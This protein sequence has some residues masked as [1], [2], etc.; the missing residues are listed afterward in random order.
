VGYSQSEQKSFVGERALNFS[1]IGPSLLVS[2]DLNDNL[3][4]SFDYA[5]LNDELVIMNTTNG[6]VEIES[7]GAGLTYYWEDWTLSANYSDWQDELRITAI[8]SELAR[9]SQDTQSPSSSLS[10]AH[11]W[12]G[13]DWQVGLTMSLHY[14]KWSQ[15]NRSQN[16]LNE[17]LQSAF[18]EGDSTFI[19]TSI[20]TAKIV[21]ISPQTQLVVGGS[22]SWN[23]LTSNESL[24]VSRN[25]RNISQVSQRLSSATV[26]GTESYGLL[27][28]Y[29]SYE[30]SES[31]LIDLDS[32]FDVGG[33]E[34][35][36]A[37]SVNL[38]YVF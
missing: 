24:A 7:W 35:T 31:W 15:S 20:S 18:D 2:I 4:L 12:D 1:P 23:Y 5:S 34:D 13:S 16:Q 32:T 6:N 30:L 19:G 38:G 8:A 14:S 21:A 26:T 3:L 17:A 37:W 33:E 28:M 25:G 29:I 22:I 11:S 27:N 36:Q 9:F 10:M